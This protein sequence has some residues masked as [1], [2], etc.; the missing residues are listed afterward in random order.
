METQIMNR[1]V[2]WGAR[3]VQAAASLV[4]GFGLAPAAQAQTQ[5][6]HYEVSGVDA[7]GQHDFH[8]FDSLYGKPFRA[9]LYIT[10]PA[11]PTATFTQDGN[12]SWYSWFLPSPTP[13]HGFS[14]TLANGVTLTT[15]NS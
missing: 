1:N 15:L 6:T 13:Q 5:V 7:G 10:H 12:A 3:I 11:I 8:L 9:H 2:S 4:L 14:V